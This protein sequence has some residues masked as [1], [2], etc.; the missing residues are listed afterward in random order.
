MEV[1]WTILMVVDSISTSGTGSEL[2]SLSGLR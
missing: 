2:P 1:I